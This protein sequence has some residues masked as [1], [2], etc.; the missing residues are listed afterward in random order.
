M[1][2]EYVEMVPELMLA[3]PGRWSG[4]PLA[5]TDNNSC[6][7]H[8]GSSYLLLLPWTVTLNI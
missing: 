2:L 4:R 5:T 1:N 7:E 8:S 3:S 6:P